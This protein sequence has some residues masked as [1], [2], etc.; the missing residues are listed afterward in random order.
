MDTNLYTSCV[1]PTWCGYFIWLGLLLS[2]IPVWFFCLFFTLR[3]LYFKQH[4]VGVHKVNLRLVL[5]ATLLVALPGFIE[6]NI[7]KVLS[8]NVF[9]MLPIALQAQHKPP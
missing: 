9:D 5:F 8:I 1:S 6:R 4:I 7:I 2:V 3:V